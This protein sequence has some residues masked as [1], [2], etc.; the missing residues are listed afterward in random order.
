MFENLRSNNAFNIVLIV[1]KY[2]KILGKPV[3]IQSFLA[4][5]LG[6][7][8]MLSLFNRIEIPV[9]FFI[10]LGVFITHII[11]RCMFGENKQ[12]DYDQDV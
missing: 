5:V 1:K 7:A 12:Y 2:W 10:V 3:L 6:S 4:G 8:V 11:F 9:Y